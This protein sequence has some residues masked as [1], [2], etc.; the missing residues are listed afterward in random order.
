MKIFL[1]SIGGFSVIFLM[2]LVMYTT[3]YKIPTESD[4]NQWIKEKNIKKLSIFL[5]SASASEKN[6]LSTNNPVYDKLKYY[7]IRTAFSLGDEQI[8]RNMNTLFPPYKF[9]VIDVFGA[10][11]Y[12]DHSKVDTNNVKKYIHALSDDW[13]KIII[14]RIDAP[15]DICTI[16]LK[17][18]MR[19]KGNT[20]TVS[21][22]FLF[23]QLSNEQGNISP[24][25][26]VYKKIKT[27]YKFYPEYFNDEKMNKLLKMCDYDSDSEPE[28]S[29]VH[30]KYDETSIELEKKQD[31]LKLFLRSHPQIELL[32]S[33]EREDLTNMIGEVRYLQPKLSSLERR[34]KKLLISN[35]VEN[36]KETEI[37]SYLE[38]IWK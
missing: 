7:A 21:A 29:W 13:I 15:Y 20:N 26:R 5:D 36:A 32:T 24:S 33:S 2:W 16:F 27:L 31:E 30:T 11:K 19:R 12:K 1:L 6:Y 18:M 23:W 22:N 35:N 4:V 38:T 14:N 10:V 17:E 3:Q 9:T 25:N 34:L 37:F 28:L 8:Y